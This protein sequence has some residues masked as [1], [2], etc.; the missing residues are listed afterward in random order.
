MDNNANCL[1]LSSLVSSTLQFP[2]LP[3]EVIESVIDLCSGDKATLRAF[4]LTCSQL[5]PRSLFILFTNVDIQSPNQLIHF[6]D[7]VQ[8][9]PHLRPIVQSLSFP[10]DGFSPFPLLSILPGLRHVTFDRNSLVKID[11]TQL[12][13]PTPL[14]GGQFATSLRSLTV[15]GAWFQTRTTFIRLL[16]AFPNIENL[17]CERL[18]IDAHAPLVSGNLSC[19]LQLQ[20][21][22]I[23]RCEDERVAELL[24]RIAQLEIV[25]P[26]AIPER[27]RS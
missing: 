5:H 1:H 2:V 15:R 7:A 11:D 9:Q 20:T 26:L 21:L 14:C 3:W 22:N 8:A 19:R 18:S 4:A 6:Y 25:D 13:H 24:F 27:F 23:L 16:S 12:S 17:T 10:W